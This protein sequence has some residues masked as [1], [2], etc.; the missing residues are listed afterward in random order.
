MRT[1]LKSN[2]IT[3]VQLGKAM[4]FIGVT[5]AEMTQRQLVLTPCMSDYS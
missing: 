2:D 1:D 3:K 5:K 4:Y